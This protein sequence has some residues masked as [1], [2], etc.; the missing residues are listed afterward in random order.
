MKVS[1]ALSIAVGCAATAHA[2]VILV[3]EPG[4]GPVAM[5]NFDDPPV[6]AGPI[7]PVSPSFESVGL[8]SVRLLG[9]WFVGDTLN[10]GPIGRAIVSNES[11]LWVQE[12]GG[13][14]DGMREGAGYR[15]GF[16]QPVA[17]FGFVFI[18]EANHFVKV[19]L[20]SRGQ[21]L[22]S[23][24]YRI[25]TSVGGGT[26][27]SSPIGWHDAQGRMFDAIHVANDRV[28]FGWG[29]DNIWVETPAP[30][31]LTGLVVLLLI[32]HHRRR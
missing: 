1:A 29:A 23:E 2:Q 12:P 6:P 19:E 15:F 10:Q 25:D 28:S 3:N 14:L 16:V 26:F 8:S 11:E 31:T 9:E 30:G 22:G 21:S 5:L 7:S 32:G 27:P 18:D 20:F 17:S 13:L 24:V 4:A